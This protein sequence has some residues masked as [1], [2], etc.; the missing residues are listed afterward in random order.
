MKK[1]I[2][3]L[4]PHAGKMKS[5]NALFNIVDSLCADNWNVTVQTTQ[6]RGHAADKKSK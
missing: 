6:Y 2:V 4:N 3:I 5:K 1:V